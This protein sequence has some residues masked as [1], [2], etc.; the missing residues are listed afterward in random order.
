MALPYIIAVCSIYFFTGNRA[1]YFI[2]NKNPRIYIAIIARG[3]RRIE[4]C[5]GNASTFRKCELDDLG[6]RYKEQNEQIFRFLPAALECFPQGQAHCTVI[7]SAFRGLPRRF[8]GPLC[9]SFGALILFIDG[10]SFRPIQKL[11]LLS[12]GMVQLISMVAKLLDFGFLA[13]VRSLLVHWP[14]GP[15]R[16][17]IWLLR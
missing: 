6:Y 10:F 4:K 8:G 9:F 2:K 17:D 12:D 14:V 11:K 5:L 1:I 13:D 3:Q 7:G 16:V 15:S